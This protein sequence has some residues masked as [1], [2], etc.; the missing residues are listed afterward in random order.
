MGATRTCGGT[1]VVARPVAASAANSASTDQLPRPEDC[2]VPMCVRRALCC[3]RRD[4]W[5][6]GEARRRNMRQVLARVVREGAVGA[7]AW[8]SGTTA[9]A[10]MADRGAAVPATPGLQGRIGSVTKTFTAATA[11]LLV[12]DGL[13][14]L[15]DTVA[16]WLPG[17]LPRGGEI[18]LRMLL[19]H[20]SGLP[21]YWESGPDPLAPRFITD[22]A[23]RERRWTP[24]QLVGLVADHPLLFTPGTDVA[25]SNTGFTVVGLLVE[26]AG[27]RTL[28]EQVTGRI[29]RP[30]RLTQTA[31]PAPAQRDLPLSPWLRGYRYDDRTG[32]S[33]EVPRYTTTALWGAG[34]MLSTARDLARFYEALLRGRVLGA[35]LTTAMT[36]TRPISSPGWIPGMRMG[37]GLW[38]WVLPNGDRAWGH[39]GEV[40]G[41]TTWAF[42][43]P[44]DRRTLVMQT[45]VQPYRQ[46]S[47]WAEAAPTRAYRDLWCGLSDRSS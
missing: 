22:P 26:A 3:R 44:R 12:R 34:A 7:W 37:L 43:S 21:D 28:R 5:W 11:L 31:F 30:L 13:L 38:E 45:N 47:S 9:A 16:R 42:H 23:L 33:A 1:D 15:D 36:R 32:A 27:G 18:T 39:Q 40:P 20:S 25:Y 6:R 35:E 46:A 8:D 14:S 19:E 2:E 41:F 17:L 29:L 24:R 4:W 10:G